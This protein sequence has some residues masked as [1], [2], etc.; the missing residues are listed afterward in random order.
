MIPLRLTSK[1]FV[2]LFYQMSHVVDCSLH[3]FWTNS[4]L[5]SAS[6]SVVRQPLHF[7]QWY[8]HFES[9]LTSHLDTNWC[10]PIQRQFQQRLTYMC[11]C[12]PHHTFR[13]CV[14]VIHTTTWKDILHTAGRCYV[15]LQKNNLSKDCHS[16]FNCRT[17]QGRHHFT[18]C[19]CQ[20]P[21]QEKNRHGTPP[22]NSVLAPTPTSTMYACAQTPPHITSDGKDVTI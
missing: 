8:F 9:S 5:K 6:S 14:T 22:P 21:H 10:F 20:K 1:V 19:H 4:P 12:E 13:S 16:S 2:L 7:C 3:Y 11:F 15:C 18:I 17:R